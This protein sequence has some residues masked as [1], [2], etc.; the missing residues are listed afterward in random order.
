MEILKYMYAIFRLQ[1]RKFTA[2]FCYFPSALTV[3]PTKTLYPS[4]LILLQN[5]PVGI[6]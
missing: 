2:K 1:G 6:L 4:F 3:L 5:K